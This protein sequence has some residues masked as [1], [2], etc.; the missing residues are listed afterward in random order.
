MTWQKAEP[1]WTYGEMVA[2]LDSI[3]KS[4]NCTTWKLEALEALKVRIRQEKF[5]PSHIKPKMLRSVD[6]VIYKIY[7]GKIH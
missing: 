6:K 3:V 4:N 7:R 1:T 2:V 5:Q